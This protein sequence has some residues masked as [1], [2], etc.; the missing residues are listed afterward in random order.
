MEGKKDKYAS[1]KKYAKNNLV[2]LA[3]DVKRE[4]REDFSK[5]CKNQDTNPS[6]VLKNFVNEYI[7][8]NLNEGEIEMRKLENV[9]IANYVFEKLNGKKD[10][11]VNFGEILDMVDGSISYD[12]DYEKDDNGDIA[13]EMSEEE[14]QALKDRFLSGIEESLDEEHS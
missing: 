1:Q 11:D 9:E 8:K 6:R 3:I 14:I 13:K 12:N 7:E 10:Y 5:A 2:K 4:I